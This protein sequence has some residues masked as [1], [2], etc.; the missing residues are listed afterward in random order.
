MPVAPAF[1]TAIGFNAD[2]ITGRYFNSKG[3]SFAS[4]IC[5]NIERL[6]NDIEKSKWIVDGRYDIDYWSDKDF[7]SKIQDEIAYIEQSLIN[8]KLDGRLL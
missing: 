2:S 7:A 1:D 6:C 5:S 8:L 4:N 3:I